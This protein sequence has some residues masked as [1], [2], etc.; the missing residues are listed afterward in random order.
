MIL[1]GGI[2]SR[3]AGRI[4][5]IIIV[6][7]KVNLRR[8]ASQSGVRGIVNIR[9]RGLSRDSI[10]AEHP[11]FAPGAQSILGVPAFDC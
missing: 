2:Q 11:N 3:G 7:V 4:Q 6:R 10:K 5:F 8:I 9:K 1:L